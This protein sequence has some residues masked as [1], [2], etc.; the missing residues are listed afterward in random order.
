MCLCQVCSK[1]SRHTAQQQHH[2]SHHPVCHRCHLTWPQ[3]CQLQCH[4]VC[5]R[6]DP[7]RSCQRCETIRMLDTAHGAVICFW[8]S[9]PLL[10]TVL[11]LNRTKVNWIVLVPQQTA[12]PVTFNQNP[13]VFPAAWGWL[14]G[15]EAADWSGH[16]TTRSAAHHSADALLLLLSATVHTA[17]CCRGA[18]GGHGVWPTCEYK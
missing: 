8:H 15:E 9:E 2:C 3:R 5:P 10:L 12:R 13:N 1:E 7:H 18:V 6:L 4:E 14:W 17:R 16:G 11:K